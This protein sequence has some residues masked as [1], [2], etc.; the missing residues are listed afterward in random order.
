[1]KPH[2]YLPR[3]YPGAYVHT[4]EGLED[5]LAFTNANLQKV[6]SRIRK[7]LSS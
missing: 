4:G 2:T 6:M 5:L 7:R 3:T 1:M